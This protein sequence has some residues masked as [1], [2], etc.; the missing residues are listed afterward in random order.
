MFRLKKKVA[1]KLCKIAAY[2]ISLWSNSPG[3]VGFETLHQLLEGVKKI[4]SSKL[5]DFLKFFEIDVEIFQDFS[6]KLGVK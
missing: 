5:Q 4:F 2:S 3:N 1:S 6:T